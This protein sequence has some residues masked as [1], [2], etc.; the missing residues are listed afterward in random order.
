[1]CLVFRLWISFL[2]AMNFVLQYK[3]NS[4]ISSYFGGCMDILHSLPFDWSSSCLFDVALCVSHV[5]TLCPF[6]FAWIPS[7]FKLQFDQS[8]C[9]GECWNTS[10][11]S[12]LIGHPV[13]LSLLVR[14]FDNHDRVV[15]AN[16]GMPHSI[17][18]RLDT[19][20]FF[21][22]MQVLDRDSEETLITMIMIMIFFQGQEKRPSDWG[23]RN[24]ITRKK[25][26]RPTKRS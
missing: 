16:I 24:I 22:M 7:N 12:H 14:Q 3:F 2:F 13:V 8:S 1:M 10:F 6:H 20:L 15:S 25:K 17:A 5:L 23:W 21:I 26:R 11:N 9:F 4:I 19:Q 18:I